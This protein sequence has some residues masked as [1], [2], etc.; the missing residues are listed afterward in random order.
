ML[1]KPKQPDK[2]NG[3]RDFRTIDSW[4]VSV[5]SYFA[6]TEAETPAIY[7]YLNTLF[8]GDAATSFRFHYQYSKNADR[9]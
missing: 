3:K 5:S 7:H 2:D 4:I 6:L 9:Q 8:T 1:L